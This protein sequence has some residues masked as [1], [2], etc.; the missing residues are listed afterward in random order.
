MHPLRHTVKKQEPFL[1]RPASLIALCAVLWILGA[2][3]IGFAMWSA[4]VLHI[5]GKW[6][7]IVIYGLAGV[8]MILAGLGLGQM[9]RWGAAL[10]G[11]LAILGS[12]NH[13]SN[14]IRRFP[15]LSSASAPVAVGAVISVLGAFLIPCG[16]VYL[17][18]LFWRNARQ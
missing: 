10:F 2:A 13:L 5:P 7:D 15:D 9:R 18:I 12:I 8:L 11:L 14:A 1:K 17:T 16:L 6:L 3:L 4:V